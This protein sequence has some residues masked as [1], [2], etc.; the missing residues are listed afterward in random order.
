MYLISMLHSLIVSLKKPFK[1]QI[2]TMWHKWRTSSAAK[3]TKRDNLKKSVIEEMAKCV[4]SAW[5][6]ISLNMI[7][8]R[9]LKCGISYAMDG[10]EDA[11]YEEDR[12][13]PSVKVKDEEDMLSFP[14]KFWRTSF[15]FIFYINKC[16]APRWCEVHLE[17]WGLSSA[18]WMTFN[19]SGLLAM[20]L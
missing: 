1:D 2:R 17:S 5:E 13:D 12:A 4:N 19:R 3:L 11:I 20:A 10:K 15:V 14:N 7:H 9:C 18:Y 8:H 6:C 16:C